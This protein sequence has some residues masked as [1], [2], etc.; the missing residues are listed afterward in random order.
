MEALVFFSRGLIFSLPLDI[1]KINLVVLGMPLTNGEHADDVTCT[2]SAAE[3]GGVNS[4]HP[5]PG[6][7]HIGP[8][9]E[10][11]LDLWIT[12]RVSF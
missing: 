4:V 12:D 8:I 6:P 3:L 1:L 9:L 2:V 11:P 7:A 10:N 5:D